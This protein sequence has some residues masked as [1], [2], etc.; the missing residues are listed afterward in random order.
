M[1]PI[2][3]VSNEDLNA[4][5]QLG[6]KYKSRNDLEKSASQIS[7]IAELDTSNWVRIPKEFTEGEY[8]LDVDPARLSYSSAVEKVGKE[9]GINYRN[10]SKDSLG[11]EFVGNN[12]W[13]N[14]LKL[15]ISLGNKTLSADEFND[16]LRLLYMGSQGKIKVYTSKGKQL[17]SKLC[18]K[19]LMDIVKVQSPWRAEWIDADFKTKEKDL[20][21]NYNHKLNDKGILIPQSKKILDKDTLMIDKTPGISLK[22]YIL[23]NHTIQGFP[24]K[25]VKSG[26]LYYW[27]PRSDNNS[28][29][30]FNASSGRA[31]L[32]CG[33]YPSNWGSD[34]GERAAKQL[35]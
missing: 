16:Y 4:F 21:V 6:F 20:Y 25:K 12:N 33:R 26:D 28:V 24:N 34:L 17:D 32:S 35:E 5:N 27:N 11:R 1:A 23:K 2:I 13:F 31:D 3:E 22:D 29:A 18:E 14:S 19:Y 10:T 9:L 7:Q 15:N 8:N 30:R